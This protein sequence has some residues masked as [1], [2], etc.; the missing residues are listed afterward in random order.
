ML[1][2]G[3]AGEAEALHDDTWVLS[4]SGCVKGP[5]AASWLRL[6]AEGGLPWPTA[7]SSH[8]CASWRRGAAAGGATAVLHGGL[9]S[10]GVMADVWL[11]DFGR[12]WQWLETSGALVARAHHCGAVHGDEL[13]V[14]SGQDQTYLTVCSVYGLNLNTA[15]WQEVKPT[16]L[17]GGVPPRID[18]NA[19]GVEGLGVLVFGGVDATFEFESTTPWVLKTSA[20]EGGSYQA[21][22]LEQGASRSPCKRACS[23]LCS[24]GLH[25]YC[26]GGFDGQQDLSDLWRLDLTPCGLR[27][28]DRPTV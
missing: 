8:L 12:R 1:L 20:D 2:F 4:V 25:V 27:M 9:G 14:H 11:L 5:V 18:A 22:P 19:A 13:L 3:G 10:S 7:R 17:G 16:S 26:F 24:D 23:S 21:H 28:R 15:V 6:E